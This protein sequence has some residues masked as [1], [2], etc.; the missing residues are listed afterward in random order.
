MAT[1]QM[2][3]E[4]GSKQVSCFSV[5]VELINYSDELFQQL[6]PE[7]QVRSARVRGP[8]DSGASMPIIP[9]Q[10][11]DELGLPDSGQ[12]AEVTLADGSVIDR[13]IVT[14][15]KLG[16]QDRWGLFDAVVEPGRQ[17]I[18]IGAI[19]MERLD[20]L[21]DCRREQLIPRKPGVLTFTA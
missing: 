12:T 19:V 6:E 16:W 14:A 4:R 1:A 8:V 5:E 13:K 18:L 7:H 9:E 20:L 21:V 10:V 11:A 2:V 17:D 15:L 3:A